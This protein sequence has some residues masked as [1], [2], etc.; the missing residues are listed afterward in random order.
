[1]CRAEESFGQGE[2][3]LGADFFK[4]GARHLNQNAR[5]VAGVF[6]RADGASVCEIAE[7]LKPLLDHRVTLRPVDVGTK[8]HAARIAFPGRM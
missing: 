2:P 6:V 4:E 5:A 8:S 3:T 7:N 1:M